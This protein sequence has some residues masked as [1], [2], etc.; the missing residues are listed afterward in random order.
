MKQVRIKILVYTRVLV[1]KS[2]IMFDVYMLVLGPFKLIYMISY[3]AGA[4]KISI[5]KLNY[6]MI[7]IYD[8]ILEN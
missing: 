4:L 5:V 6:Y 1:S 8:V 7:I 3:I 2:K